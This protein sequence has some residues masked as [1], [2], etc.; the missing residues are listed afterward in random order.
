[1]KRW[2]LISLVLALA[3]CATAVGVAL[4]SSGKAPA[5]PHAKA[6]AKVH[7]VKAAPRTVAGARDTSPGENTA[8]DPDNVQQGDQTGPEDNAQSAESESTP[9]D[10]SVDGV[11]QPAGADHQCPPDCAPGEQ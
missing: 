5:R 4:A 1:M 6:P 3:V 8:S 9:G 11:E 2:S 10:A 7:V